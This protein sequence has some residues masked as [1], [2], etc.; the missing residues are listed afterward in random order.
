[1]IHLWYHYN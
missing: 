1:M